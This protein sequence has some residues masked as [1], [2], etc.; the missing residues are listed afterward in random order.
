M[1]SL[2]FLV[3]SLGNQAPYYDTFHSAG[4]HALNALQRLLPSQ[5]PFTPTRLG[6]KSP[7]AS[8]GARYALVQSPTYM[9]TSGPWVSAAWRQFAQEHGPRGLALVLVHDELEAA[10]GVV[11]RRDWG[12][13]HRGHNGVKSVNASLRR[14]DYPGAVLERVGVGIG[15]PAERDPRSV[16]D[17]VLAPMSKFQRDVVEEKGAAGVLK[18]LE[19][20]EQEW[21]AKASGS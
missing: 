6:K 16:A 20:M 3:I 1:P 19:A 4:H 17:Y 14:E 2:R 10:L 21:L 18:A 12:R 13:S 5:P 7:L 11:K 9:N 15:R 8:L